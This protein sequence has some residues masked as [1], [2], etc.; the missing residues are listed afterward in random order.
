MACKWL[1][2]LMPCPDWNDFASYEEVIYSFFRHDFIES[3]P[4]FE[5]KPVKIRRHPLE[6][7]REQTFFHVTSSEYV[8]GQTRMPDGKR[9]ERIKWIRAFIENYGCDPKLCDD[10]D[11]I[12]V[13]EEPYKSNQ[14]VYLLF[15][16]ENYV[17]IIERREQY[18][19][20]ITAYYLDYTHTA[21]KLLRKYQTYRKK[22]Q[23]APH[24]V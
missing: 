18:A 1:P 16:E 15:E 5:E 13:W 10:C 6:N 19:L 8:P 12:K 23:N 14:R 7:N 2:E 21:D 24:R 11:G 20:L 22:E 3:H 4:L 9:C 17:V